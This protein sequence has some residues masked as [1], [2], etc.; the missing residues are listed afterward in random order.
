MISVTGLSAT[1]P[2]R[3]RLACGFALALSVAHPGFAQSGARPGYTLAELIE[4][5]RRD[6]P[7]LAVSVAEQSV[8]RAGVVTARAYP[9][10]EAG[11]EWG[12]TQARGDG[13]SGYSPILAINQP[14]E[15]PWL[16]DAR[17][18]AADSRVELAQLQ[19]GATTSSLTAAIRRRFFDAVRLRE[20]VQA[21]GEDLALTEQIR[22][23]VAVRVRVGEGAR[24]DL[25]RAESEVAVAR[26]NLDTARLRLR[27]ASLELRRLVGPTLEE[28]F[29]V[30][31]VPDELPVL[32]E[33]D[34]GALRQ[35]VLERNPDVVLARQEAQ[36]AEHL[37]EVERNSVLPQVTLRASQERDPAATI[38]RLGAIVSIPLLNRREGPIAEA[39]AQSQRARLA[40]ELKRFEAQAA[41]DAAWQGYRAASAQVRAI[42]G[43]ILE[44]ARAVLDIA[45]AAY[46]FGERGIL[47]FLDAQRQFRLV[48]NELIVA[49]F[50]QQSARAEIERLAGR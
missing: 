46:R 34:Q 45:E 28:D 37:L 10:P 25:L 36:R 42:E 3:L 11:F 1:I 7:V 18:R 24:F 47:E 4:L 27:Q 30:R 6:S 20:E 17:A 29:D 41:F 22:E 9:N 2:R 43:G 44:R 49:R 39:K 21:F 38:N 5:A 19:T 33:T 13:A 32:L 16:R 40:L 50:E 48:R 35:A 8:A 12:R 15:N 14:I 31:S 23:R 26:K